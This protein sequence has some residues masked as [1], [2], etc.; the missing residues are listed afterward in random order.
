M[1]LQSKHSLNFSKFV[2]F[3]MLTIWISRERSL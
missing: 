2:Y 3:F 1:S